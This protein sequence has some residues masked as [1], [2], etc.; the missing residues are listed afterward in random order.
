[1]RGD[2]CISGYPEWPLVV[3]LP[4]GAKALSANAPVPRTMKG[5]AV[6][7]RKKQRAKKTARELA[8][9]LTLKEL[10][11]RKLCPNRYV[12]RWFYRYGVAP[13]DDNVVARCKAYID[14]AASALGINDRVLR[15]RGVERIRDGA[16]GKVVELVFWRE[17]E[18]ASVFCEKS[19]RNSEKKTEVF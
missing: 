6:A 7:A 1:M 12:V 8:W 3:A 17:E 2:S 10:D 15:F 18:G 11:G 5:M 16:R 13:D 4:H 9:A 14:G 19:E